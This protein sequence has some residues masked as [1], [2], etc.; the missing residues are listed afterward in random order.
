M[1]IPDYELKEDV[2][3]RIMRSNNV[4]TQGLLD[5]RMCLVKNYEIE[6]CVYSRI[7]RSKNVFTQGL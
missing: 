7:M 2:Y 5:R 1:V 4:F 6:K 3:L